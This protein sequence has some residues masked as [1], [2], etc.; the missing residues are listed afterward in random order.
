MKAGLFAPLFLVY[1]LPKPYAGLHDLLAGRPPRSFLSMPCQSLTRGY[2][3]CE[4]GDCPAL[5]SLCPAKALRGA[6]SLTC[7]ATA[8]LFFSLPCHVRARGYITYLR[9]D[10]PAFSSLCPAM[11]WRGATRLTCRA[12][13]PP[14]FFFSP[15]A[16]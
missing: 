12:T 11:A 9:G 13:A 10:C 7:G 2:I 6:T 3:T 1:A 14:N 5:S 15:L 16:A 8:P 4:R